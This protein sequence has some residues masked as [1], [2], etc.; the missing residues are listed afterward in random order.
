MRKGKEI[1]YGVSRSTL[2][3]YEIKIAGL[4]CHTYQYLKILFNI[5]ALYSLILEVYSNALTKGNIPLSWKDIGVHLLPKKD[6][7]AVLKN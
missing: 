4:T 3:F 5:H 6:D 2:G 7:Q 1:R